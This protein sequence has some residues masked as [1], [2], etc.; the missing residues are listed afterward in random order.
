M[1]KWR[2]LSCGR[3][4]HAHPSTPKDASQSCIGM[5]CGGD[6]FIMSPPSRKQKGPPKMPRKGPILGLCPVCLDHDCADAA[7]IRERERR[8]EL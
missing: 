4:A 6:M 3:T 5:N 7:C 1:A 8:G 2:C